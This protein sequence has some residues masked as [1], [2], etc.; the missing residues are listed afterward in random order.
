LQAIAFWELALIT[1]SFPDRRKTVYGEFERKKAPTFQQVTDICLAEIKLLIERLNAGIDPRY[2]PQASTGQEPPSP[3][4]KLVPQIG[5]PLNGDKPITAAPPK[6]T[7]RWEV[8]EAAAADLAKSHSSPGNSQQA[9]GREALKKGFRKAQQG[10]QQAESVASTYYNK[11][12]SSY[13]GW[14]FRHTIQRTAKVVVLGA[15]Y[16]RISLICN[17]IT[18]LTN[19]ATFSLKQDELGRFHEGVPQII[20]LFTTTIGKID[21]YMTN[22]PIHWSDYD[23]LKKPE[24]ER[25]NVPEVQEVRECLR[26]GLERILGSFNEYLSAL[27]MSKVEIMDAK[28]AIGTAKGPEMLQARAAK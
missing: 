23:A 5:R 4:V 8:A 9:Y 18:A 3:P 25:K 21:D 26:E 17:A 1:D 24:G 6:P 28:K 15:P 11:L 16:S 2:K 13:L 22:I 12:V 20:R 19:L 27:G 14:P 10:A 7:S